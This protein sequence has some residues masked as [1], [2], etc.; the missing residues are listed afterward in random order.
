MT[1]EQR[2]NYRTV[3]TACAFCGEPIP[4][5]YSI[6]HHLAD[7]PEVGD[8]LDT[9]D[10]PIADGGHTVEGD[11]TSCPERENLLV[12]AEAYVVDACSETNRPA[13]RF[14]LD[15]ARRC[16][17]HGDDDFARDILECVLG[18]DPCRAVRF[19]VRNALQALEGVSGGEA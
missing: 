2:D 11:S 3:T 15:V 4:E 1:V 7:C 19:E 6:G 14:A 8:A 13:H 18:D 10:G 12:T 5:G 9:G 17:K 16:L